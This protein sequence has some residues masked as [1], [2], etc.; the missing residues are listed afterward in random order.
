MK[1]S[2]TLLALLLF[3]GAGC[4]L[5]TAV[6]KAGIQPS[7]SRKFVDQPYYQQTYLISGDTL[8]TEAKSALAGFELSKAPLP[9]GSVLYTLK[10]VEGGYRDQQFTVKPGE[11][12]YFI[13]KFLADD[14]P[15]KNTD[16]N[17][18]DDFGV[19]VDANGDITQEPSGFI[20][21]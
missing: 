11:K 4:A 14:D 2:W 6:P 8:S 20:P 9:D 3:L 7:A 10:A 15:V 17:K 18:Q 19:V 16:K 12:L 13:E 21:Q 1:K 5:P